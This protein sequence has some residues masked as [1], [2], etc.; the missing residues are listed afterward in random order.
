LGL[1]GSSKCVSH[2]NIERGYYAIVANFFLF[3]QLE[4][5]YLALL[6]LLCRYIFLSN[7]SIFLGLRASTGNI[8]SLF[9]NFCATWD[10]K[11]VKKLRMGRIMVG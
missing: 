2:K 10:V 1:R 7:K 4:M 6:L 3:C 5:S 11:S 8:L 9:F